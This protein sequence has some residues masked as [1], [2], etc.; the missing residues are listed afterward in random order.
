MSA[1]GGQA[2]KP[3]AAQNSLAPASADKLAAARAAHPTAELPDGMSGRELG[4]ELL[5]WLGL[6]PRVLPLVH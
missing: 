5:G 6:L 4:C 1:K 2:P 3:A